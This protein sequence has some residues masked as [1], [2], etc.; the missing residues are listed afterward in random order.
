MGTLQDFQTRLSEAIITP[1]IESHKIVTP[2]KILGYLEAAINS[3]SDNAVTFI[4]DERFHSAKE[5]VTAPNSNFQ[6][7]MTIFAFLHISNVGKQ[8][9]PLFEINYSASKIYPVLLTDYLAEEH[10]FYGRVPILIKTAED[11]QNTMID[12]IESSEFKSLHANLY[13]LGKDYN[14]VA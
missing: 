8:R 11:L 5:I 1:S 10:P 6:F 12:F 4:F 9:I 2:K 14:S 7:D 3:K 13:A